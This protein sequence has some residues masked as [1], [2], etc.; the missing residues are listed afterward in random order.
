MNPFWD[1]RYD[2]PF[3][4]YGKE[5]NR[6]FASEL[7]RI[8]PGKILLPGEGEGRN[9]VFAARQGWEVD[10]FDQSHIAMLKA[11]SFAAELGV[12]IN[13]MACELQEYPFRKGI[14][15]AVGL[16]FF[17]VP[18]PLRHMLHKRITEALK[19]GG[20]LILEAFHTSQLGNSTGG[21]QSEEM[22]FDAEI[23]K[24]DFSSLKQ[25]LLEETESVLDEGPFHQGKVSLVRYIGTK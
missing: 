6:F 1:A 5:P 18:P 9:A 20:K 8:L 16:I 19:P 15:D 17:H 12:S 2:T 13:Y 24:K 7:G 4:V 10:A 25:D 14:Y 3:F 23:L 21:P 11:R 22:L